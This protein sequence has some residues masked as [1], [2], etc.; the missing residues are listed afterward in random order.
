MNNALLIILITLWKT[1]ILLPRGF[2]LVI[3]NFIGF[4]IYLIPLKRN[5]Y[6]KANIELCFPD[7]VKQ[8]EKKSTEKT[9]YYQDISYLI[10]E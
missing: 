10:M 2:Q 9:Y 7:K 6:S 8:N 5:K 4:L 1:Q 3:S